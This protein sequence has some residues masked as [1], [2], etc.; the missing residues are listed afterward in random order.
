MVTDVDLLRSYAEEHS[1]SAFA[2]LVRRHI[3]LVYSAA[4]R[5]ANGNVSL[6]EDIS[7]A[8]FA[9][10]ARKAQRLVRHPALA[11]WLYTCVRQMT[12]NVRRADDRRQRREWEAQTMNDLL[13][14]DSSDAAWRQIRP[15]LD[16][17]MHELNEADRAAVVLR[18]FEE[19]SLKEVGQ[20]L[21][22]TE[23]AAHMRVDRALDKLRALL[24]RRGITSTASGLAA[25]LAVGAV[26]SAP[27]GLAATVGAGALATS[28]TAGSAGITFLKFMSMTKL[29]LG[30]ISALI[31]AGLA[32]PLLLQH[33]AQARLRD[34]NAA[35]REQL[36]RL[37]QSESVNENDRPASA[38]DP[39]E[40]NA[41]SEL[42][43]LRAQIARLQEDSREL[44]QLKSIAGKGESMEIATRSWLSRVEQ[45]KQH[46]ERTPGA[47][48]PEM[49]FVTDQDWLNAARGKLESEGDYRRAAS[50]LRTAGE[51]KVA[52]MLKK[53]LADYAEAHDDKLPAEI[54]Q[55][56]PHLNPPLDEAVLDRW[57][58][59]PASTIKSLGMGGDVIITQK[60]AVDDVFDTRFGIGPNGSGSTDFMDRQVYETMRPVYDAYR[61]AHNGRWHK[62]LAQLLP[63]ITTPE[64]QAALAKMEL[65]NSAR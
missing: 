27:E 32:T 38:A 49:Q 43:K 5:E 63:Y 28:V 55:L 64:Q 42:M 41:T 37:A 21:G 54:S 56:R 20:A 60:A 10:L 35:L 52:A 2:E 14:S 19:R 30:L 36:G 48:I 24:A 29:K 17:A 33:Q 61:A 65:K 1:E 31:V 9:E 22:L 59:A 44:A 12:A 58:V 7:Q 34:E 26:L 23:N 13:S 11:G 47:R 45:L 16:D 46:F 6:A 40:A 51:S 62:D 3:D 18:F 53:A 8:V 15:V 50:V 57:E 39:A 25:T 4:L